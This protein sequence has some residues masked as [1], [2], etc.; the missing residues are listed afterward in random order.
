[1]ID[2]TNTK[3]LD[4]IAIPYSVVTDVDKS[5]AMDFS[6]TIEVKV[7]DNEDKV[8]IDSYFFAYFHNISIALEQIR[9]AIK[10]YKP[11]THSIPDTVHDTTGVKLVSYPSL[12][13]A[14]SAP[15]SEPPRAGYGL[16]LASLLKPFASEGPTPSSSHSNQHRLS[17]E[18]THVP[19]PPPPHVVSSPTQILTPRPNQ[20]S[21]TDLPESPSIQPHSRALTDSLLEGV[22]VS[23]YH[24]YPPSPSPSSELAPL[25]SRDSMGSNSS[26]W[27][28]PSWLRGSTKRV[29]SMS[30]SSS[31]GTIGRKGVSEVISP[32]ISEH[33]STELGFSVLESQEAIRPDVVEKFHTTFAFDEKET[34]LGC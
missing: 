14:I 22:R 9:D 11:S 21:T 10:T 5:T 18:Y 19:R 23:D 4:K 2:I 17:G 30:S 24:T 16:R 3:L 13:R 34:L 12:D 7:L 20:T 8:G 31:T 25:P 33:A 29:F 1:M 28:V 6:D 32:G 26:S 15:S 27:A